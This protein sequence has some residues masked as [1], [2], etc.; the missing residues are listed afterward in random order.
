MLKKSSLIVFLAIG[1][2]CP[3]CDS[4]WKTASRASANLAPLPQKH[5]K[6][7][8][9]IYRAPLWGLRGW[10]A[11]HTWLSLKEAEA[12]SYTVYE[13]IGWRKMSKKFD[14]VLRAEKDIPDRLWYGKK[15]QILV[16]LR[17]KQAEQAI[18]KVQEAVLSYP[19]KKDY[20]VIPGPNSN[21]FIAWISCKVPELRLKLSQRAIGKNYGQ[22]C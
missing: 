7:V 20:S 12:D 10:F 19:Y 22:S 21:T 8:I 1:L 18:P 6:A 3:S 15:P 13:V 2:F 4:G 5:K 14:S 11:D 17:G 16:D 9:Q